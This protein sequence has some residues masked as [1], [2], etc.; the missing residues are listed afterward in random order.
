M[1]P[2]K[3]VRAEKLEICLC[4]DTRDQK[5]VAHNACSVKVLH[6]FVWFG[7]VAGERMT[8]ISI[9]LSGYCSFYF[10]NLY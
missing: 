8:I 9:P 2:T 4:M 7:L 5:R 6:F 10:S 1:F 3:L